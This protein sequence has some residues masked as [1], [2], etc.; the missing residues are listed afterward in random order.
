MP[1][2]TAVLALI[3]L[4]LGWMVA[5]SDSAPETSSNAPSYATDT[6]SAP[7]HT[8]AQDSEMTLLMRELYDSL[9]VYRTQLITGASAETSVEEQPAPNFLNRISELHSASMTDNSVRG[10]AFD[11]FTLAFIAQADSLTAAGSPDQT[12]YNNLITSCL[13]CHQSFCPGPMQKIGKLYWKP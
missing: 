12:R 2:K 5:C 9:A 7:G 1:S 10:P 13:N 4:F 11:S 6:A 3:G 8:M